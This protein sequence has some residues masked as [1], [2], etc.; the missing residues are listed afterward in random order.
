[1]NEE[2]RVHVVKQN[3]RKNLYMRYVDPE[4]GEH[5]KR[6]TG[7][8]KKREAERSAAKWEA[9]LREGRYSAPSRWL[10]EDFREY[11]ST[12]GLAGLALNSRETYE[13]TLNV[14]EDFMKPRRLADVTTKRVTAFVTK[15]RG[16]KRSES[17]VAKHLRH[18][19]AAMRWANRR[20]LL[21]TLPEFDMPKR[22]KGS[23]LMR[24]RPVSLEEFERMLM[25]TAKVTD[26]ADDWKFFLRGLWLS[27][28]RLSEALLLRWDD[29]TDAIVIDLTGKY[30][31]L[32][33][34]AE[35][36][37]GFRDRLLP[38]TPD[39]AALLESVPLS[40]RHGRVFKNIPPKRWDTGRMVAAIGV[41]AGVVVDEVQDGKVT[42]RKFATAHCLRKS[43]GFRWS[44]KVMP[45][46]LKEL[47]RHA[48]LQTTMNYYVGQNA[49]AT[50]EQLWKSELG[51]SLGST[52]KARSKSALY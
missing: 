26:D 14:F 41:K 49:E 8:H 12:N 31:M 24:G 18:L 11:Y 10:W 39:F 35:A 36:E 37:K 3:D 33:I 20:G 7:T 2:I 22:A 42:K 25:V 52:S 45:T 16:A 13:S 46:V 17:T 44:R 1:M 4:T 28:L 9:E 21:V 43:F 32:R 40:Q 50:A 34:P 23:K 15:L 48:S 38:I 47:M 27:G 51:S 29:A 30:P 6:S 5:V 19:K